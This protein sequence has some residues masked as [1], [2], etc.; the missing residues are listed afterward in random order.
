MRNSGTAAHLF[1]VEIYVT[2]ASLFREVAAEA[3]RRVRTGEFTESRLAFLTGVSQPHL[4]NVLKGVRVLSLRATDRLM[5]AL[6]I[7][8]AELLER[9][10]SRA[11]PS[12]DGH[13]STWTVDRGS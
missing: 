7:S 11:C 1:L 13:L 10:K 2:F 5:R 3:R 8:M 6:H 9:A 4:H 12:C